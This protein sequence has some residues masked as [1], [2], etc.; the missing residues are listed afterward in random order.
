MF[1]NRFD[2]PHTFT[3]SEAKLNLIPYVLIFKIKKLIVFRCRI[4]SQKPDE[5][6]YTAFKQNFPDVG[7]GAQSAGPGPAQRS[8]SL[9]EALTDAHLPNRYAPATSTSFLSM[10]PFFSTPPSSLSTMLSS[11]GLLAR[12]DGLVLTTDD[13][14]RHF[15]DLGETK[16]LDA[17]PKGLHDQWKFTPSLMDP[18]SF[19]FSTFANQPPGY[20]TPTPGGVN[21]LFHSQA[22]DL[23]TPGMGMN[24]GTPIS[25]P[26]TASTL[27]A[28]STNVPLQHYQQQ[29]LQP[30]QFENLPNYAPQQVFAPS[31][32]LQHKD[33]GYE[34]MSQSPQ[35]S[36]AKADMGM[37]PPRGNIP[38]S[39]FVDSGMPVPAGLIGET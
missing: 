22:G 19:V 14:F 5:D 16:D 20:Y 37:L 38:V 33:S 30:H 36:P 21:T 18:N 27:S 9:S 28:A 31:S 34:A 10:K 6:F 15:G 7:P 25:L 2:S 39:Q 24:I 11:H 29:L 35:A 8:S 12:D 26:Q 32:F 13:Y 4:N 23:H 1:R 17:T 3:T